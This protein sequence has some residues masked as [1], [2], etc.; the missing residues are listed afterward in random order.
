VDHLGETRSAAVP[1]SFRTGAWFHLRLQIFPD[2]RCGVAINGTPVAVSQ[3]ATM[4]DSAVRVV[5]FGNS[6]GTQALVGP[7]RL[8]AG[9]PDDIDWSRADG[10]VPNAPPA[11]WSPEPD[12]PRR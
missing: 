10:P 11:G 8:R 1:P 4:R 5:S 2:G 3:E 7:V 6:A 9:V 12:R